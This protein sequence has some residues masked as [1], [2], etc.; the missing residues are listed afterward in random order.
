MVDSMMASGES[1]ALLQISVVI[2]TRDRPRDLGE[3][4]GTILNQSCRPFE[5]IVVDD[6]PLNSA[7]Q[8]VASFS[9]K[10]ESVGCRLKYVKGN[11]GGVSAER[12]LGVE[13]SEGDAILFLDDDALLEQNVVESLAT[14]LKNH[15]AV[16]GVQ[17]RILVPTGAMAKDS[18]GER[19]QNA[20]SKALMLTYREENK[21]AVRKS[22][23]SILPSNLTCVISAQRLLGC[24]CCFRRQT[25]RKLAFDTN[26]KRWSFM[27]DLDFSYRVYRSNPNA[28]C[29]LPYT[30]IVHKL[31]GES[32][33]PRKLHVYMI[34]IYWSYVFFKD[35]SRA[36]I[37]NLIAFLW[38][39][40][41]RLIAVTGDLI[42][43]RKSKFEWWNLI[44]VLG[45]YATALRNL[46]SIL[47]L[48]LDFFNMN[49]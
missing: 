33:L 44:H 27:E 42:I 26:L 35:F 28:L 31:S 34:T 23:M 36:S 29:V 16:L 1:D 14:F 19:L 2:P 25:F 21:Q 12:N 9:S 45:S 39:A 43:K 30:R 15:P 17:P 41:G 8:V 11:C 20:V 3:L 10:F 37:Q 13:I 18:L 32:R 47:M 5:V 49:L 24:G 48:R 40:I 38:A 22:G 46:K 4:L 7:K 6:S